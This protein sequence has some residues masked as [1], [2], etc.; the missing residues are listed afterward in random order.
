MKQLELF[1]TENPT[2]NPN[3]YYYENMPEYNNKDIPDAQITATFKFRNN[4][5]FENF[6]SVIEKYLYE[7]HRVFDGMQSK[8]KKNAWYP[9]QDHGSNYECI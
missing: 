6:M 2:E 4:K 7:G 8:T 9:H 5:D 1:R 3:D